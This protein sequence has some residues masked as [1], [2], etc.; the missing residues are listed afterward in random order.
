LENRDFPADVARMGEPPIR[1]V[2]S[3]LAVWDEVKH[4]TL[5]DLEKDMLSDKQGLR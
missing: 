1:Y 5:G 4:K 3:R 2:V